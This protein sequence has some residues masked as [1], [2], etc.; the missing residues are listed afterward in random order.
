VA[1]KP[2]GV[3]H[4]PR[5]VDLDVLGGDGEDRLHVAAVEGLDCA[6]DDVDVALRHPLS[7]VRPTR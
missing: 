3:G 2:A 7:T 5:R 1:V 6:A 4:V